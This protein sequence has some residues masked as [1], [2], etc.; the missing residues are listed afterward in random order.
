MSRRPRGPFCGHRPLAALSSASPGAP[1]TTKHRHGHMFGPWDR[2]LHRKGRTCGHRNHCPLGNPAM[3]APSSRAALLGP[4]I[5]PRLLRPCPTALL[6]LRWAGLEALVKGPEP[7]ALALPQNAPGLPVF[8]HAQRCPV[9]GAPYLCRGGGGGSLGPSPGRAGTAHAPRK[10]RPPGWAPPSGLA[11][12]PHHRRPSLPR[13]G[14]PAARRFWGKCKDP[15]TPWRL[16]QA[17]TTA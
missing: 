14:P 2:F 6:S 12:N 9:C 11:H 13:Q 10:P 4:P 16:F 8:S 5:S 7:P 1:S 17:W 15:G 3:V